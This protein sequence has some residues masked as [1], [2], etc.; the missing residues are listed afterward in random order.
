[1]KIRN[2]PDEFKKNPRKEEVEFQRRNK[3]SRKRVFPCWYLGGEVL[4]SAVY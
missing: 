2:K 4:Q 3:I 1:M